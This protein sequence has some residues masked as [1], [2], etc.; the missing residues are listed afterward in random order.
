MISVG[1]TGTGM[2]REARQRLFDP[3]YTIKEPGRGTG[4]GLATSYGIA[5]QSQGH[6]DVERELG[7]GTTLSV[8][9]PRYSVS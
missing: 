6:I 3:F 8:F 2:T 4:L 5:K 1:D 9:L 7:V